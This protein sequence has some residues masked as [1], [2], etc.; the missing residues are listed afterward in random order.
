MSLELLP[1]DIFGLAVKRARRIRKIR[2]ELDDARIEKRQFCVSPAKPKCMEH[3]AGIQMKHAHIHA[4][5]HHAAIKRPWLQARNGGSNEMCGV[6]IR[7]HF[8]SSDA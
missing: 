2:K 5:L 6:P 4:Q 3:Q 8:K 7:Y 1:Y